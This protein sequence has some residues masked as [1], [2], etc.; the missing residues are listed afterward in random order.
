MPIGNA[1]ETK[2]EEIFQ[3][4]ERWNRP[5]LNQQW[6]TLDDSE[7]L[8]F[9]KTLNALDPTFPTK[10]F[11]KFQNQQR[12]SAKF[13]ESL[14]KLLPLG[15]HYPVLDATRIFHR[16]PSAE[17]FI[18]SGKA[19]IVILAG[20]MGSRLGHA[21]P[22]GTFPVAPVSQKSLFQIHF[23]KI[24]CLR[25]HYDAPILIYVMTNRSSHDETR[26]YFKENNFFGIP[27]KE[28]FFFAQNEV[29][30][31]NPQ[32]GSFF[33]TPNGQ[34]CFG[35]DG[36]GGLIAA[37]ETTGAGDSMRKNG[38]E[39]LNTFHVD[40]PLVPV[41]NEQF[42]DAHLAQKSEMS[43]IAIEKKEPMELLGH[44]VRKADAPQS[45]QIVEYLDFPADYA[46][47]TDENGRLKFWAGSIGIHLI[48]LDF[49]ERIAKKIHED[50]DFL[51]YHLPIKQ[52]RTPNGMEWGIKPERFIFDILP[53]A[54][55]ALVCR[56]NRENVFATLKND[57][58]PVQKHCSELYAS[59]LRQAGI[60]FQPDARVEIAPNFALDVETLK[61]KIPAGS[62]L[63]GV[64]I[65]LG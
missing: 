54:K 36:H 21:A 9:Q 23:E 46:Q 56:A 10:I 45:L 15:S 31:L 14:R 49:L 18:A 3:T 57:P 11:Q 65:F 53:L 64:D 32:D 61:E 8:I 39:T 59:W 30:I 48:Q 40:N 35:P 4:F 58:L 2:R 5:E 41:L 37:L 26:A 44:I 60:H 19:A 12:S 55:N 20:G 38:I 16:S 62:V 22:K 24:T 43:V 13:R 42:L 34:I 7:R 52:V 51:P 29:P 50:P 47:E 28:V 27:E 33:F 25:K 17:N 1:L 63:E 6:E